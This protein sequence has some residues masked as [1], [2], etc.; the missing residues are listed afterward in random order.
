MLLERVPLGKL[1]KQDPGLIYPLIGH[2]VGRRSAAGRNDTRMPL[3][4]PPPAG[5]DAARELAQDGHRGGASHSCK[6]CQTDPGRRM[7]AH[8]DVAYEWCLA[9]GWIKLREVGAGKQFLKQWKP[10]RRG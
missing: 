1:S 2:T 7:D 3:I 6:T 5:R 8:D 9:S 4:P 10:R